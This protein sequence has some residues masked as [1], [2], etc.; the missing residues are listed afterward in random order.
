MTSPNDFYW[1]YD[2]SQSTDIN[3]L[4]TGTKEVLVSN[5]AYII[6]PYIY[7]PQITDYNWFIGI[8]SLQNKKTSIKYK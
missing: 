5:V 2:Y 6:N 7:Q 8:K 4:Y 1:F 3:F